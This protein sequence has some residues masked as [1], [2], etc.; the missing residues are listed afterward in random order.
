MTLDLSLNLI[1]FPKIISTLSAQVGSG[2]SSGEVIILTMGPGLDLKTS[3]PVLINVIH[4]P[5][6][7]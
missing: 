7:V 6:F 3:Q 2:S 4:I 5:T 1:L